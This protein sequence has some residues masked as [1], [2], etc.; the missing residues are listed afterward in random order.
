M[1]SDV[2]A[3]LIQEPVHG[4]RQQHRQRPGTGIALQN[5]ACFTLEPV[6]RTRIA[7]GA[8]PFRRRSSRACW[9][10]TSWLREH[11]GVMGGHAAQGHLQVVERMLG[12]TSTAGGTGRFR[13]CRVDLRAAAPGRAARSSRRCRSWASRA[14]RPSGVLQ[15]NIG[16]NSAAARSS[17]CRTT[18]SSAAA[19]QR[20]ERVRRRDLRRAASFAS[21][22]RDRLLT[23]ALTEA[24]EGCVEKLLFWFSEAG[25][26]PTQA[27]SLVRCR[28]LA[29]ERHRDDQPSD[30]RH[31][32]ARRPQAAEFTEE[33][34]VR[35][36]HRL[37]PP[38]DR[39]LPRERVLGTLYRR[40]RC[41]RKRA[42]SSTRSRRSSTAHV[43][44]AAARHQPATGAPSATPARPARS[45]PPCPSARRSW[46]C[47]SRNRVPTCSACSSA[48]G[49]EPGDTIELLDLA[50]DTLALDARLRRAELPLDAA[51]WISV[52]VA[53]RGD[54]AHGVV[55]DLDPAALLTAGVWGR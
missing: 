38:P 29:A 4:L 14:A 44:E 47:A 7:P 16:W 5:G 28:C 36:A 46:C 11:F 24:V 3:S 34:G 32:R 2:R 12:K 18:C 6:V 53:A 51:R 42:R 27:N 43:R 48:P 45:S 40:T 23:M 22:T 13:A 52:S 55:A 37:T 1:A 21:R 15:I 30:R 33:G 41:A 8:R 9:C 50:G 25:I 26:E 31:C 39:G 49:I 19:S 17:W 54:G 35:E 10:A 20:K